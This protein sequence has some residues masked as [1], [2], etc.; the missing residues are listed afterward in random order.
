MAPKSSAA[1]NVVSAEEI[2]KCCISNLT[3][4]PPEW[5]NSYAQMMLEKWTRR[6]APRH[7]DGG[8]GFHRYIA[9]ASHGSKVELAAK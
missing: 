2:G 1:I 4:A 3:L 8:S 7:R 6:S 9:G 5:H